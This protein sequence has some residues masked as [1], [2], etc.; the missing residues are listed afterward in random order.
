VQDLAP[1]D[2]FIAY[3]DGLPVGRH[4]RALNRFMATPTWSFAEGPARL[5]DAIWQAER[6]KSGRTL[7]DDVSIVWLRIPPVGDE[8]QP[9]G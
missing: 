2:E 5:L 1:G 7:D 4:M 3:T 6:A 9:A 8:L